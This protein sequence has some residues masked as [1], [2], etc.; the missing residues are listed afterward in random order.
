L[1]WNRTRHEVR[2]EIEVLGIREQPQFRGQ[3][4]LKSKEYKQHRDDLIAAA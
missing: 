1:R 4:T 2:G 3:M